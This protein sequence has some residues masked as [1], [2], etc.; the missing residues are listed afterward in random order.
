[1]ARGGDHRSL[2]R[3]H[4][5]INSVQSPFH[6]KRAKRNVLL[7]LEWMEN[8]VD[9]SD[10]PNSLTVFHFLHIIDITYMYFDQCNPFPYHKLGYLIRICIKEVQNNIPITRNRI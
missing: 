2:I 7:I 5:V 6:K 3:L 9:N 10:I 8:Y 4:L 1:M